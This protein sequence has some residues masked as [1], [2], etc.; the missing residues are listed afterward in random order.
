LMMMSSFDICDI[1]AKTE[2]KWNYSCGHSVPFHTCFG[3]IE[4]LTMLADDV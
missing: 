2:C 3:V 1:V 4:K